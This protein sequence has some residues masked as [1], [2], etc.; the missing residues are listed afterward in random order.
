M[1]KSSSAIVGYHY[2]P[3]FQH[4]LCRGMINA[5]LAWR[6]ADLPAW[7]GELTA[8]GTIR[9]N[10]P[11]LFGGERDQ[12]GVDGSLDAM[13]GDDDQ[14][15]NP[16]LVATF[17]DQTVAWRGLC[18]V[19]WK[20]GRFG[21]MNPY[22][23]KSAYMIRKTS[24][25]WDAP[26]CWYPEKVDILMFESTTDLLPWID[27]HDPR[28]PDNRHQYRV[29]TNPNQPDNSLPWRD[30]LEEAIAEGKV[31]EDTTADFSLQFAWSFDMWRISRVLDIEPGDADSLFLHFNRYTRAGLGWVPYADDGGRSELLCA[32]LHWLGMTP[33]PERKYWTGLNLDGEPATTEGWSWGG[34]YRLL[35]NTA[36]GPALAPGE[37]LRNHCVMPQEPYPSYIYPPVDGYFPVSAVT[38]DRHVEVRRV[39]TTTTLIGINP[40]H[41]LYY[42]NTDSEYGR[43]PR[44]NINEESLI[45]AA[46]RLY[47]EG[48]G[49]CTSYNHAKESVKDFNQRICRLIGGSFERSVTDG[50]W[51]L[52]LARGDYDIDALPILTDDDILNFK[53]MPTTL[54]GVVNSVSVRYFDPLRKES[55]VTPAVRALG[56]IRAFG[57]NHVTLEFPEIPNNTLAVRVAA[58]ELDAYITPKRTFELATKRK[59]YAWR[60]NQYFRLQTPK[61]GIANMVCILGEKSSGTLRSGAIQIRATQDVYSLPSTSYVE[62][63]PG[64]DTRPPTQ[65]VRIANAAVFEAPFVEVAQRLSRADLAALPPEVGYAI[66]VATDPAT[67]R[68]FTARAI[69]D[70]GELD[71]GIGEWCPT[72]RIEEAVELGTGP[73]TL[74]DGVGLA[75]V[76]VGSPVLVGNELCRVDSLDPL[77]LGR[78]CGDTVSVSHAAGTRIWFY[79]DTYAG[80]TTEFTDGET[81]NVRLLTNT[82]SA[83]SAPTSS[84]ALELEFVGRLARPYPPAKLRIAGEAAPEVVEGAFTVT[85]VHRDRLVQADVLVDQEMAGIGPPTDVRIGL[86]LSGLIDGDAVLLVERQDIAGTTATVELDFEGVVILELYSI[87]DIDESLQRHERTFDYTPPPVI[88]G[89]SIDAATWTPVTT[90]IDGGEVAP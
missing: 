43:E 47:E 2:K 4:G 18:T 22:A 71:L 1:G 69:T 85:W 76:S 50:Q 83:Q 86:R 45:A 13:F 20:G 46:D 84:P 70:G 25:G 89:S 34:F 32:E 82:W 27:D 49:I 64:V 90:V 6:V 33:G 38:R 67:S 56:L 88:S 23:Q 75:S 14:E 51:Y 24:A 52:D 61:R 80:G 35:P 11:G 63:E 58:R 28:N 81:I 48:F 17:G 37:E 12:G 77:T 78:G 57:E 65:A 31:P 73:F 68:D 36:F 8:S 26:G 29:W 5:L 72:A 66:A 39:P 41:L 62:V 55:I 16:Y 3:A 40:A 15:P 30:S 53:E 79:D 9:V 59:P 60:T 7:E 10:A 74:I 42:V 54:E 19:A 87:S 44:A 21:A